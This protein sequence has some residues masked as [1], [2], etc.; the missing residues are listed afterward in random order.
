[1]LRLT[2]PCFVI[3]ISLDVPTN[4]RGAHTN[5]T[6]MA[7]N[8]ARVVALRVILEDPQSFSMINKMYP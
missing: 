2:G 6:M 5:R 7:G 8:V 1:M 3:K 4:R